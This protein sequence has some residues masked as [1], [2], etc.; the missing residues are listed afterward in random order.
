MEKEK[1]KLKQLVIKTYS[2]IASQGSCCAMPASC[3]APEIKP[4]NLLETGKLIGYSEE[5]LKIRAWRGKPRTW[6]REPPCNSRTKGRR[7]CSRPWKRG[8]V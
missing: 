8:R 2:N 4:M 6:M 5:E 1:T 7:D 3:C